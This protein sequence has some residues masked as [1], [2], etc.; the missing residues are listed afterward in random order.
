MIN[1]RGLSAVL[2]TVFIILLTVTAV[3]IVSQ[4]AIPF[5]RDSLE[6][7]SCFKYRDYFK[8]D[9]E[10]SFNCYKPG[11]PKEYKLSLKTNPDNVD[12]SKVIGFDF[13]FLEEGTATSV[14]T[15]K[16]VHIRNKAIQSSEI[17][18]FHNPNPTANF[19]IP[20]AE[21]TYSTIT[22][23]Y[24]TNTLYGK[25]EVYPVLE[26]EKLCDPSDSI[27]LIQCP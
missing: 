5:V 11:N 16:S 26:E 9:E 22:Y 19:N 4:F 23:I 15:A 1:K 7:T 24:K 14:G 2:A 18:M 12:T 27:K 20:L 8:F 6:G 13:R 10:F 3:V 17:Y 21:G 25:V